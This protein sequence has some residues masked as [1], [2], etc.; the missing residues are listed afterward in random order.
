[1]EKLQRHW[2]RVAAELNEA[3]KKCSLSPNAL[4]QGA[5]INYY[6]AR[7]YLINGVDSKT[8]SAL[9]LC[10]FFEVPLEEPQKLQNKLLDALTGVLV[11]TWDGSEPHA[12]LITKLI[13]ST[14]P[15]KI[16]GRN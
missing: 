13:K 8:T 1:M 5:K 12:E 14:K 3:L 9:K 4:A 10:E 15:F 2:N 7:R 6:A 11:D 16:E